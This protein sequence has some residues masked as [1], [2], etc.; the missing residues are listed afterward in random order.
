[1]QPMAAVPSQTHMPHFAANAAPLAPAVHPRPPA[2]AVLLTRANNLPSVVSS[3]H[4]HAALPTA[5]TPP[6]APRF[7][8]P[9]L[10]SLPLSTQARYSQSIC[11]RHVVIAYSI[12]QSKSLSRERDAQHAARAQMQQQQQQHVQHSTNTAPKSIFHMHADPLAPAIRLRHRLLRKTKAAS[13]APMH[14]QTVYER[15]SAP[16]TPM[17]TAPSNQAMYQHQHQQHAQQHAQQQSLTASDQMRLFQQLQACNS[18]QQS[19]LHFAGSYPPTTAGAPSARPVAARPLV[20]LAHVLHSHA[21]H[22]Q[23]ANPPV[24]PHLP[25]RPA[26][27]SATTVAASAVSNSHASGTPTMARTVQRRASL[28]NSSAP[29]A[30]LPPPHPHA[31]AHSTVGPNASV[32]S[33]SLSLPS[34]INLSIHSSKLQL[35]PRGSVT[36]YA[37]HASSPGTTSHKLTAA[38][39]HMNPHHVATAPLPHMAPIAH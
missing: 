30:S 37:D 19:T 13:S 24:S 33:S 36:I 35:P 3:H 2:P 25:R 39:L 21:T 31:I 12:F 26:A 9:G 5:A 18:G 22:G 14:A 4:D 6:A 7:S 27:P 20:H 34:V 1:M 16:A 32:H 38:S 29:H 17:P 10:A 8:P 28:N 23:S 15:G 11:C